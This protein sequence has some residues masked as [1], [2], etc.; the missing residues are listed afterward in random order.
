M[1]KTKSSHLTIDKRLK[2]STGQYCIYKKMSCPQ[3]LDVGY[4]YWDDD[5]SETNANSQGGVLPG[6]KYNKNTKMYFCCKTNG[7]K[8][9][10]ILLPSKSP[11]YL[12][13]YKS[14]KCQMVI[15]TVANL[16]WIYFDTAHR[17][18]KDK[19]NQAYPHE[20]GKQHPTIYYCY[21]RGKKTHLLQLLHVFSIY[22]L[23]DIK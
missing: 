13:A 4:V 20:A 19:G 3:G 23:I 18:N 7:S 16:E 22:S 14:A 1:I 9:S 2:P 8:A 6:G 15:W 5:N 21:Y 17:N 11:F 12:L 10:A